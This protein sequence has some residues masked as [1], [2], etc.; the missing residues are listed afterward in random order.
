VNTKGKAINYSWVPYLIGVVCALSTTVVG[1]NDKPVPNPNTNVVGTTSASS[2]VQ[3]TSSQPSEA[4]RLVPTSRLV[5]QHDNYQQVMAC[6]KLWQKPVVI[7][8]WAPWCHSCLSMQQTVL[9]DPSLR[10]L[11]KDFIWLAVDTDRPENSSMMAL[12]PIHVWP[13]FLVVSPDDG[14][15][16]SRILGSASVKQVRAFLEQGRQALQS[17]MFSTGKL[18]DSPE[19]WVWE[20]DRASLAEDYPKAQQSYE[21]AL[22]EA[23]PSWSRRPDILLA[24]A[25]TLFKK[26]DWGAC[27]ILGEQSLDQLGTSASAADF[28]FYNHLCLQKLETDPKTARR[29]KVLAKSLR[30]L[31]AD[32]NA[33]LSIDDRSDALRVLREVLISIKD[34]KQAKT[35]AEE[36]A[37]LLRKAIADSKDPY[38]AMT[39][40]WPLSEVYVFLGK[41]QE[42]VPI[43]EQS[44]KALPKEYDPPFRL[45]WVQYKLRHWD[46]ALQA[47]QT[48]LSLAYGPRKA[49][50]EELLGQIYEKKAEI[51]LARTHFEAALVLYKALPKGQKQKGAEERLLSRISKLPKG[52]GNTVISNQQAR[53]FNSGFHSLSDEFFGFDFADALRT[54]LDSHLCIFVASNKYPGGNSSLVP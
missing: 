27:A 47:A 44:V 46:P 54:F 26:K 42:I 31:T 5:W 21:K 33:E 24:L 53:L 4:C 25:R 43:L 30:T 9:K 8:F 52:L 39:H 14:K 11:A 36:Q 2:H 38:L 50:M 19:R 16:L 10:P 34:T 35:V 20:G 3:V 48:A 51:K 15:V 1:C 49:R 6:A 22:K 29:Q 45:A 41:A 13:T 37:K 28:L 40:N 7:D 32:P 18:K 23:P 17:K 12:F